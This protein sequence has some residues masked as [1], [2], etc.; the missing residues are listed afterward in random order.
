MT[1]PA[2]GRFQSHKH[3]DQL[4]YR[5]NIFKFAY[6][7]RDEPP[8][9]MLV[10]LECSFLHFRRWKLMVAANNQFCSKPRRGQQKS[11]PLTIL[12]ST[13]GK[14]SQD[15]LILATTFFHDLTGM[16]TVCV[17]VC[18]SFLITLA[19]VYY[20]YTERPLIGK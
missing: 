6:C 18:N 7:F 13:M 19:C 12:S 8:Q 1:F 14:V 4:E 20:L 17:I 5:A 9:S 16:R 15:H 11:P 10:R 3:P 2:G